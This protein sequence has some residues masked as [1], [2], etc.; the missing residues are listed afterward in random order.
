MAEDVEKAKEYLA[1]AIG[2]NEPVGFLGYAQCFVEV[3]NYADALP[4]LERALELG[5][6]H[7][8]FGLGKMYFYGDAVKQDHDRAFELFEKGHNGEDSFSTFH[9]GLCYFDGHGCKQDCKKG[10]EL[11]QWA[12]KRGVRLALKWLDDHKKK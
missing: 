2:G 12:A 3:R 11:I 5:A 1:K 10:L 6:S 4:Y 8:N 7:A 9:L